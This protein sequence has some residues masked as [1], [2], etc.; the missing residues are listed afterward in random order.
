MARCLRSNI[1]IFTICFCAMEHSDLLVILQISLR[2]SD[3]S[4]NIPAVVRECE[5]DD[6]LGCDARDGEHAIL[7][8]KALHS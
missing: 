4:G 6:Q 2:C 5:A 1:T 7:H 3:E 8:L